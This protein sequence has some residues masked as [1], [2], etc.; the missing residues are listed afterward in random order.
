MP[1]TGDVKIP[2]LPLVALLWYAA[3]SGLIGVNGGV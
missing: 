2:R 3:A 1:G